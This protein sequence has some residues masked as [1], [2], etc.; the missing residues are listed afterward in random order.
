ML[1]LKKVQLKKI[2][3]FLK[4]LPRILGEE[5]FLTFL[6]LLI[7]SLVL[8]ALTFYKYNLLA[9][10]IEPQITERPLKFKEKTYE[11]V[12]KIWQEREERFKEADLK[13]YPNPFR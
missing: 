8:G 4:K 7:F 5:V 10:K 11:D 12:L 2:K 6:G 1:K 3:S 9:K 13:E